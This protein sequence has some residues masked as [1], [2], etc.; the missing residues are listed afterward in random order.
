MK[1]HIYWIP[2]AQGP[3]LG[4]MPRPR[5]DDWLGDEIRSL[6][7]QGVDVLVSLLTTGEIEELDLADEAAACRSIGIQF[8]SFPIDDRSV[9]ANTRA[10]LEFVR[11]LR[12]LRLDGRT[13]VIHCRAGI[14]RS[15]MIAAAVLTLEGTASTEAFEMIAAAR[16]CSVPD[17]AEQAAWVQNL[18]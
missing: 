11:L 4:I 18:Y 2:G 7:S 1:V 5:G 13:V 6:R 12:Q 10:A 8:L 9:P 16:G 15:T 14:G 17:T 3:P